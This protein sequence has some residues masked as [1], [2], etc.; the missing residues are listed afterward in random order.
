MQTGLRDGVMGTDKAAD[1]FKEYRVRILDGSKATSEA[2]TALGMNTDEVLAGLSDGSLSVADS[3]Q[4]VNEALS[5][6]EDPA[7]RMQI[8]TALMGTQFE[9]LGDE[10]VAALD[11]TAR[12]MEDIGAQGEA[13][14]QR[15]D[16]FS[17]I[18]PRLRAMATPALLEIGNVLLELANVILP[19]VEAGLLA[20][21]EAIVPLA[22][23][24]GRGV[25][26]VMEMMSAFEVGS[27]GV[28]TF[29][30][31]LQETTP[32]VTAAFDG[33]SATFAALRETFVAGMALISQFWT[34]HGDQIIAKIM[35]IAAQAQEISALI[36]QIVTG[37]V[38]PML[39]AATAFFQQHGDQI[40]AV[41]SAAFDWI[42]NIISTTLNLIHGVL[43]ATLQIIQGDFSG[44][45]ETL[46]TTATDFLAG[47]LNI[48]TS[49]LTLI[50]ETFTLFLAAIGVDF[51]ALS[52]LATAAG[53][54]FYAT[55]VAPIEAGINSIKNAVNSAIEAFANLTER[56]AGG[57]PELPD[58][59]IPGFASGGVI[60][61]GQVAMV[62]EQ[63][64]ELIMPA[65]DTRV[66]PAGETAR[67]LAD[68]GNSGG[69]PAVGTVNIYQQPGESSEAL[70]ERVARTIQERRR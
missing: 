22:E 63:G 30:G 57:L 25:A 37:V 36:I 24:F 10:A 12:S 2:L 18:F 48:F 9:D 32:A 8:A 55:F 41:I 28:G 62:G 5:G 16:S 70:A 11:L 15:I 61:A 6:V 51:N 47:W 54:A 50:G 23:S 49:G 58:I 67:I 46:T 39:Q 26:A 29:A 40:M 45:T 53:N 44:A 69:G 59:D 64:R 27:E 31:Q 13:T 43:T 17:E 34:E 38:Q 3:F 60:P 56:I 1:L 65:Q 35:E 42:F 4:L 21:L 33:L 68:M 7:Q 14:Q 66:I 20:L 52:A 19:P